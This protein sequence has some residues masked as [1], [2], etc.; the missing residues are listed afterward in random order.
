MSSYEQMAL[1]QRRWMLFLLAVFV[2]GAGF[3]PYKRVFLGLILGSAF[4]FYNL[5]L[6][7]KR[8]RL[9]GDALERKEKPAGLG[10]A[11]RFAAAV[12]AI[13][14]AGQYDEYFNVIAVIIGLATSYLVTVADFLIFQLHK[15]EKKEGE[16]NGA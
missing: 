8:V 10:S 1:R 11:A 7:Q 4:S 3:T 12:A 13:I 15:S 9:F 14:I 6:L 16:S 5:W 2:I